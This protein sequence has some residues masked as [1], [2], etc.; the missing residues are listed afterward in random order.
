[1]RKSGFT[2]IELLVVIAIIAILAAILFP[3]F[4]RAR[5]K[6]RQASCQSNLKQIG[7]AT[8]MYAQDYDEVWPR[9]AIGSS[10]GTI[11]VDGVLV[12][13][14]KNLQLWRCPSYGN[15]QATAGVG[16]PGAANCACAGTHWRLRAGYGPNYGDAARLNPWPV[17]SGQAMASIPDPAGTLWMMDST[18]VVSSPP[19]IWPCD[20]AANRTASL[21]HNEGGNVVFCDGHVKWLGTGGLRE[22]TLLEAGGAKGIWSTTYG[23]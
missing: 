15:P 2:L 20:T 22:H 17:P 10:L 6:A 1:M 23:D 4:A 9:N 19:G 13:Y 21:R 7:I 3:V 11:W 5:E 18:C 14:V 12:P 8:M 16:W